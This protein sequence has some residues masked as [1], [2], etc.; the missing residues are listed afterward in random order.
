M[1]NRAS[2]SPPSKLI[3]SFQVIWF[4][5]EDT[6]DPRGQIGDRLSDRE[7]HSFCL[8]ASPVSRSIRRTETTS[9]S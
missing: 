7:T 6:E 2:F 9:S 1:P 5:E 3:E 4:T 8:A